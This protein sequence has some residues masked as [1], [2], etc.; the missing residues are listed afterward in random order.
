[1][2][3]RLTVPRQPQRQP[4]MRK[5]KPLNFM[6]P[7]VFLFLASAVL[8]TIGLAGVAGVLGSISHASF[9]N[10]PYWI[11]WV[12][13]TLGLVV[14]TA[15]LK[16]G[17]KIQNALTLVAAV[18]ATALGLAGLLLGLHAANRFNMPELA[19]PSDHLAHLTVGVVAL[20]ASLNRNSESEGAP[21]R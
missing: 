3:K 12:H 1:M 10:P 9:F 13:L 5:L 8:T 19:D 17:R 6:R 16:G 20:W 15:A 21:G 14:L 7:R 2:T 4:A 11:N 18:L